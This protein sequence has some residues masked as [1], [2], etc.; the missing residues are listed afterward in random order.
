MAVIFLCFFSSNHV[1]FCFDIFIVRIIII[2]IIMVE[3]KSFC[4]AGVSMQQVWVEGGLTLCFYFTL[5]PC[6]LVTL[7]FLFGTVLCVCYSRYGTEM[8]PKFI[9]R[10]RLYRLQVVL[11][12]LLALQAPGWAVFRVT[13][14]GELPGYVVLYG[15]LSTLGWIWAVVLLRLERKRVLVRDRTRG[16]SAVMLLYWGV[17]FAAE[18]LAFMS[19][20]SPQWW[21]GLE[22]PNQQ[23]FLCEI[24]PCC[25]MVL[26]HDVP[27]STK[28]NLYGSQWH[29][30]FRN[31]NRSHHSQS[32]V[33]VCFDLEDVFS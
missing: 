25:T 15:C 18:N 31:T 16:H 12:V 1:A 2:I 6:I 23:V 27:Y 5:V 20:M 8:E 26:Y 10:S 9:P 33:T 30:T 22:T 14:G 29:S 28:I 7:S 24:C 3:M 17:A 13:Q 32:I 21:W 4:E 19:W 11:S